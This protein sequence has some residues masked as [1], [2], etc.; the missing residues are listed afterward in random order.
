MLVYNYIPWTRQ[1]LPISTTYCSETIYLP[2]FVSGNKE[3]MVLKKAISH[4][5]EN[6]FLGKMSTQVQWNATLERAL[7]EKDWIVQEMVASKSFSFLEGDEEVADYDVVW[8]PFVI[9]SKYAGGFIRILSPSGYISRDASDDQ[10][11]INSFNSDKNV[12]I[13]PIF[14]YI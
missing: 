13:A 14:S 9:E 3:K 6:V 5:G 12:G 4:G 11:L 7:T 8:G 10:S 1:F 2:D